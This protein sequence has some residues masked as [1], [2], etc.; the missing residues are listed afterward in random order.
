[1]LVERFGKLA[2]SIVNLSPR[3]CIA[4]N[5]N[6][7]EIGPF[8]DSLCKKPT[9]IMVELRLR[10]AKYMHMEELKDFKNK[11]KVEDNIIEKK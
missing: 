3:S 6:N 10:V 2:F 9:S 7:L 4:P 5:G 1:M 11:I 8:A